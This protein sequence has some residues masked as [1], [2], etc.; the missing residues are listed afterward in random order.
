MNNRTKDGR[1]Q[2]VLILA[3]FA[4]F[5][6]VVVRA[7]DPKNLNTK[8]AG[9]GLQWLF[10]L[11]AAWLT[12]GLTFYFVRR[13][14]GMKAQGVVEKAEL[15]DSAWEEDA[16]L[17]KVADSFFK[18]QEA[19]GHFDVYVLK[20]LVTENYYRLILMELSVLRRRQRQNF[21]LIPQIR[22]IKIPFARDE[23]DNER[24][25]VV[26]EID[27]RMDNIV[28]DTENSNLLFTDYDYSRQ[29]WVFRRENDVWKINAIRNDQE[30]PELVEK[31]IISFS[32]RH[33]FFY[34]PDFGQLVI[35]NAGTIFRKTNFKKSKISNHVIGKCRGRIVQ[36]Y[37][38]NSRAPRSLK[39]IS[40]SDEKKD[41]LERIAELY[42]APHEIKFPLAVNY[43]SGYIVAQ[44]ILPI[45][46]HDILIK[47]K[48]FFDFSPWRMKRFKSQHRVFNEKFSL[49][50]DP[51]DNVNDCPLLTP[52]FFEKINKIKFAI[53]I[54]IVGSFLY[55]YTKSRPSITYENMFDI[56]VSILDEMK[57]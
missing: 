2:F 39:L 24:D 9:L 57:L 40:G 21:V 26:A 48:D 31:A 52:G 12:V 38:Y 35:P 54:E 27:A 45:A 36:F 17:R 33:D 23:A 29:F 41:M 50:A 47:N 43:G 49:F 7:E 10:I 4:L 28:M 18:F 13:R 22:G 8:I 56:L 37:T 32:Q 42:G 30:K 55:I 11:L 25:M 14:E 34:D 51:S 46:C 44:A 15:Y 5:A 20:S 3:F 6:V 19:W 16:L 53:N 1:M